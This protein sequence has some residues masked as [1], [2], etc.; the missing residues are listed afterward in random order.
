MRIATAFANRVPSRYRALDR[1]ADRE[2]AGVGVDLHRSEQANLHGN[3]SLSV[4]TSRPSA[5]KARPVPPGNHRRMHPDTRPAAKEE[6]MTT[7]LLSRMTM[8]ARRSRLR[9][10][11][12][13]GRNP[14]SAPAAESAHELVVL[15]RHQT[16]EGVVTY[17]RCPCGELQIWLT[18]TGRP[19]PTLITSVP[20]PKRPPP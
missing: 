9:R 1:A 5:T 16:S 6:A 11:H 18:G 15:S 4:L 3:P 10:R 17:T 12:P 19:A 7:E 14:T 20:G 2:L 8:I 13:G